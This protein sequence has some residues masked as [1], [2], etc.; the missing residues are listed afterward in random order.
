MPL[1]LTQSN[2]LLILDPARMTPARQEEWKVHLPGIIPFSHC[3]EAWNDSSVARKCFPRLV[4]FD[5]VPL[6]S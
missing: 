4:E 6:G 2:N 5:R 3:I 1:V